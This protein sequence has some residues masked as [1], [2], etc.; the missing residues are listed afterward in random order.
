MQYPEYLHISFSPKESGKDSSDSGY[1][2]SGQFY[3]TYSLNKNYLLSKVGQDIMD[4][5]STAE[6]EKMGNSIVAG[7][8][9][10]F[11]TLL[12]YHLSQEH[13]VI[14]ISLT[15]SYLFKAVFLK[16]VNVVIFWNKK[17]C[18][19]VYWKRGRINKWQQMWK[20]I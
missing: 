19:K 5:A 7:L 20:L 16:V 6:Y 11:T 3:T 15:S 8:D 13:V 10:M 1:D 12:C 18:Q 14:N 17:P 2:M 4:I 9:F